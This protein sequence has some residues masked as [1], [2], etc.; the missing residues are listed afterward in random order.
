MFGGYG[1]DGLHNDLW[2]Y[3]GV[4][5]WMSGSSTVNQYGV[6]S[7]NAVPGARTESASF[8]DL[9]NGLWMFGGNGYSSSGQGNGKR[10]FL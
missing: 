6:Y 8:V 10:N 4:W 2:R 3:N 1:A 9:G 7:G 5:T